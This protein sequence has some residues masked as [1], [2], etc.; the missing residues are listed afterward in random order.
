MGQTHLYIIF[1]KIEGSRLTLSFEA[2]FKRQEHWGLLVNRG[3]FVLLAFFVGGVGSGLYVFAAV[4]N[5]IEGLVLSIILVLLVKNLMHAADAT[6]PRRLLRAL[7]RPYTSW[8][9]RGAYSVIV[10]GIA[11]ILDVAPVY[12]DFLPWTSG[13]GLGGLFRFLAILA[14][15]FI[16]IY[17]G[18]V[19]RYSKSIRF[20]NT[21]IL[22][23]LFLA[24]SLLGGGSVATLASRLFPSTAIP[25][26]LE[27]AQ[28]VLLASVALLLLLYTFVMKRSG[29]ISDESVRMLLKGELRLIFW[30]GAVA[31]G[32]IAPVF[33][34]VYSLFFQAP[35]ATTSIISANM[36]AVL[37]GVFFL[38]HLVFKSG[39]YVLGD[40]W[41]T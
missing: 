22:P 6:H 16:M 31:I 29:P 13:A 24:I 23:L 10:F 7:A 26:T 14:A 17:P 37:I 41:T 25:L 27:L 34:T 5:L 39:V 20:W 18:F 33:F 19:L 15:L 4:T 38:M 8:I 3:I 28:V 2:G 32:L 1:P 40:G 30:V 12:V 11:A 36:A 21:P 35:Q 9:S